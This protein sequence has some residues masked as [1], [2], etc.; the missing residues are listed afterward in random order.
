MLSVCH[1]GHIWSEG[2][3]I[4]ALCGAAA[5]SHLQAETM[6]SQH[7]GTPFKLS[8]AIEPGLLEKKEIFDCKVRRESNSTSFPFE[9]LHRSPSYVLLVS[10]W[11]ELFFNMDFIR[12]SLVD[13]TILF[14]QSLRKRK[15]T[16]SLS[17]EK[18]RPQ[19]VNAQ[20]MSRQI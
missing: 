13:M 15:H 3:V 16:S 12:K 7:Q 14:F 6:T 11:V 5:L 8:G 1:M 18:L 4:C 2:M 20:Q 10:F 19:E 17:P 9:A